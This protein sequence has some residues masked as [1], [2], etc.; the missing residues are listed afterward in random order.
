M[1][2]EYN[3]KDRISVK[4]W[5]LVNLR[6]CILNGYFDEALTTIDLLLDD[7]VRAEKRK[8]ADKMWYICKNLKD[9]GKMQEYH[10]AKERYDKFIE[11]SI[12]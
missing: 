12:I 6:K 2:N 1:G 5:T 11:E 9:A 4:K 7:E 10:L 8:K 3:R